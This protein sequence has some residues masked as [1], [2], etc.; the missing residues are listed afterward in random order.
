MINGDIS[1]I[2]IKYYIKRDECYTII[3]GLDFVKINKSLCKMMIDDEEYEITEKIY[4]KSTYTIKV[5][6]SPLSKFQKEIL[7]I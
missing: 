3:F 6:L 7:I 5:G 1:E 4:N 2:N